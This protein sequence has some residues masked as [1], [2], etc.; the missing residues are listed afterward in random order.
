MKIKHGVVALA[1]LLAVGL[2]FGQVKRISLATGGTGGVY[3]PLGGGIAQIWTD[4]VQGVEASAEVVTGASVENVRLVAS[5]EAQ[6]A[7]G[8]SGVLVGLQGGMFKG[9]AQPK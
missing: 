8:T 1:L 7:L 2:A 4:S 3:Y 5:R 9:K 6:A